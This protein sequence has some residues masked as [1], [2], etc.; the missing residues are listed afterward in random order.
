M[1]VGSGILLF[2]CIPV[3]GV[4][5]FS[6]LC[7][8]CAIWLFYTMGIRD[9]RLELYYGIAHFDEKGFVIKIPLMKKKYIEYAKCKEI[10]I[11]YYVHGIGQP[12]ETDCGT[13]RFYI[14]FT[15]GTFDEKYRTK[16]VQWRLTKNNAKIGFSKDLYDYLLTVLPE[17]QADILR[18]DYA[19]LNVGKKRK[20]WETK[21]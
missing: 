14:F 15:Y 8:L 6:A 2:V 21:L 4:G 10:G 13:Y 7:V 5:I 1:F 18:H 11:A 20:I 17:R 12:G 16:I 9:R 19:R 3:E